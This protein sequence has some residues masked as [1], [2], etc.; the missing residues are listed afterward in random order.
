MEAID[1]HLPAVYAVVLVVVLPGLLAL[2]FRYFA[3]RKQRLAR[4]AMLRGN[5]LHRKWLEQ[6]KEMHE[7]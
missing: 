1:H 7:P 2:M 6:S 3:K 4:E 5:R